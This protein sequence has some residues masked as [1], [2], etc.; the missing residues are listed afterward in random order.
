MVRPLRTALLIAVAYS[1]CAAAYILIS[2]T[3]ASEHSG[4]VEELRRIEILKGIGFV[5]GS[6]ALLFG[7]NATAL[8]RVRRNEERARRME[9]ALANAERTVLAGTF[10]RTIAH[11]INNGLAVARLNLEMLQQA[12][13]ATGDVAEL[14]REAA[15]AVQREAQWN[16]RFFE[17]GGR[18]LLDAARPLDLAGTVESAVH[19]A[20]QHKSARDATIDVVAPPAAPY[21]GIESLLERALLNLLLNAL[22][23][24]G[25]SAHIAC[26]LAPA[27]DGWLLT[28]EDNGPGVPASVRAQVFEPFFTTKSTGTGL[29]LASVV[30]CAR[31]HGGGVSVGTSRWGGASFTLTLATV[32]RQ[33][34]NAPAVALVEAAAASY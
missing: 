28:V 23:A 18:E 30:A 20:R 6:G 13:D 27:V 34:P 8:L 2:S 24:A 9:Q 17:L 5:I 29:G 11:D 14:A 22:E 1:A 19:L 12:A 15:D 4:S 16:Q 32:G 21:V 33:T 31:F 26:T 10:A 3:L 7:L 25:P